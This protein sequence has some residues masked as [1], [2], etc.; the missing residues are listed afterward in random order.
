MSK[1][2][3]QT[4]WNDAHPLALWAHNALRSAIRRGLIVRKPCEVCGAAETDG[5]H[6]DHDRPLAVRWL[7]RHHHRQVHIRPKEEARL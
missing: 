4:K 3:S 7:C 1:P 2:S 6:P 5:H